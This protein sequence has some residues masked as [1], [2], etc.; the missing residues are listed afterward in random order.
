MYPIKSTE[1]SD[2]ERCSIKQ[3]SEKLNIC[4]I[5]FLSQLSAKF[6]FVPDGL[7]PMNGDCVGENDLLLVSR[8]DSGTDL[9]IR[10]I[11]GGTY[12]NICDAECLKKEGVAILARALSIISEDGIVASPIHTHSGIIDD[13]ILTNLPVSIRFR[14]MRF[15]P[16][17]ELPQIFLIPNNIFTVHDNQSYREWDV[18][19][20]YRLNENPRI[21]AKVIH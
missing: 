5:V 2:T 3:L 21:R 10:L 11:A 8:P 12:R 7:L 20:V 9:D 16:Y 13:A 14:N 17:S 18:V 1:T 4:S 15:A 19:I 6:L